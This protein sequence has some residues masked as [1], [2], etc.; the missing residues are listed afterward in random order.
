MKVVKVSVWLASFLLISIVSP[1]VAQPRLSV[2]AGYQALHLPDTWAPAGV[3][4]DVAVPRSETWSILGEFGVVHDG[5]D[6]SAPDPHDFNIYNL[7]GGVRW[8]HLGAAVVPF[9]QLIAGVQI[10][11]SDSDTDTAFMFQPGAGIHVPLSDQ[12]G[13]SAQIDYRPV[14]YREE[15]VQ[16]FRFV[17]GVRWSLP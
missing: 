11:T 16:E 4:V 3:N 1:A 15:I 12:W 6:A 17:A 2:T 13:A 10:S 8:N 14:F 9:V 7:G 5:D